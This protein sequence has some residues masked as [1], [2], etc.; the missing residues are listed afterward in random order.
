MDFAFALFAG[1]L[2]TGG[3]VLWDRLQR[4]KET[5]LKGKELPVRILERPVSLSSMPVL[6]FP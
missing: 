6:F 2:N 5:G 3:V 1:L 4:P